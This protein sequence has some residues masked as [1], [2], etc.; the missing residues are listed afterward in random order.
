MSIAH[1]LLGDASISKEVKFK[2]TK[3][4]RGYGAMQAVD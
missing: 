3:H 1:T 4:G 2:E